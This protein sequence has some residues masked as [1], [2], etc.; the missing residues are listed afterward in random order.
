MFFLQFV[1]V[2]LI[3]KRSP[4][5]V[6]FSW[7]KFDYVVIRILFQVLMDVLGKKKKKDV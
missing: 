2:Y 7:G 5:S 1:L 4:L 6:N 3:Q